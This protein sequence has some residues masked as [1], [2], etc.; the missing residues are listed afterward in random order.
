MEHIHTIQ[1]TFP[2][3][4]LLAVAT[5]V[6]GSAWTSG[7]IASISLVGI[8][9][10][11]KAPSTSAVVWAELYGQGVSIMPK[12]AVTVGG[13]YLYAAWERRQRGGIW[14]GFAVA[15]ALVVGIV[16]YTLLTMVP[17][18]DA[19][20]AIADGTRS[21]AQGEASM[22]IGRWGVLN[23]GRCLLPL[24]GAVAGFVTFLGNL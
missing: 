4:S 9:A 15:A 16:P 5:G 3:P 14:K 12:I 24:A 6:I 19:L 8:P 22:L 11:L 17:T 10:A 13:A 1:T 23:L 2:T 18:N 7:A 20:H 21:A